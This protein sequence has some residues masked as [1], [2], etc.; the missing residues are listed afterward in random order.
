MTILPFPLL[1][2]QVNVFRYPAIKEGGAEHD[3]YSG[4][5]SHVTGV[6]WVSNGVDGSGMPTDDYL[7]SIGGEDKCVFQ[8]RCVDSEVAAMSPIL[9]YITFIF[10]F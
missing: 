3:K 8:W 1:S 10:P 7:L 5:S 4:H 9:H 6:Q 2:L